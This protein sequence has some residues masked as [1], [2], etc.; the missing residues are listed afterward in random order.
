[1][2]PRRRRQCGGSV[3]SFFRNVGSKLRSGFNAVGGPQLARQIL[4]V[5]KS[6]VVPILKEKAMQALPVLATAA[7]GAMGAGRKGR[8]RN[9]YCARRRK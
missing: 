3:K 6:T 9:C 2:R 1:M 4:P 5:I 8:K 7:M